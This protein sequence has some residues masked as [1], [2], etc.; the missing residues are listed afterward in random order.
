MEKNNILSETAF[1]KKDEKR[2]P[3][4]SGY[5]PN[6]YF[7]TVRAA[8]MRNLTEEESNACQKAIDEMSE[9]TGVKLF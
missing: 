3:F 5:R 2:T 9:P 6:Y 7:K 4:W 1:T 8:D